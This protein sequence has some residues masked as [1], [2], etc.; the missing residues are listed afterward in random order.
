LTGNRQS[1]L[2]KHSNFLRHAF[3]QGQIVSMTKDK[4]KQRVMFSSI[5]F[6]ACLILVNLNSYCQCDSVS[7]KSF[8]SFDNDINQVAQFDDSYLFISTFN[9]LFKVDLRT[10]E[11]VRRVT[12]GL[13]ILLTDR[14]KLYCLVE[15]SENKGFAMQNFFGVKPYDNNLNL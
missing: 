4:F 10:F 8:L 1:G 5:L 3:W 7:Y 13:L 11:I 14:Y 6:Y 15:A 2:K 9:H 12:I